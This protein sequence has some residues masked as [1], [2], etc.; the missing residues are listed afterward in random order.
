MPRGPETRLNR[1][2]PPESGACELRVPRVRAPTRRVEVPLAG[3]WARPVGARARPAGGG[4]CRV[5]A[6]LAV[7]AAEVAS[8]TRSSR[9]SPEAPGA[10]ASG[11]LIGMVRSMCLMAPGHSTSPRGGPTTS[12]RSGRT[13]RASTV[14]IACESL[15]ALCERTKSTPRS[16][17]RS[18]VR[19]CSDRRGVSGMGRSPPMGA[20]TPRRLRNCGG[21]GFGSKRPCVEGESWKRPPWRRSSEPLRRVLAVPLDEGIGDAVDYPGAGRACCGNRASHEDTPTGFAAAGRSTAAGRLRFATSGIVEAAK[22][23]ARVA[24]QR[25]HQDLLRLAMGDEGRGRA[26]LAGKPAGFAQRLPVRRPLARAGETAS[27]HERLC[28]QDRMAMHR[29]EVAREP[30]KAQ[31]QPPRSEVHRGATQPRAR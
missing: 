1:A 26:G 11:T 22:L 28:D 5:A 13:T 7:L 17:N 14:A 25:V 15:P 29:T 10:R 9:V 23:L 16:R 31:P 20:P 21:R 27:I 6:P 4:P 12:I 19:C 30:A 18:T 24:G 2:Q 8:A 3:A